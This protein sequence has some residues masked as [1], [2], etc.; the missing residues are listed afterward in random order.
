MNSILFKKST[1]RKQ[2][3]AEA[4]DEYYC[5]TTGNSSSSSSSSRTTGKKNLKDNNTTT[6]TTTAKVKKKK[7]KP[8]HGH[9]HYYYNYNY[10]YN[11]GDEV[12][13]EPGPAATTEE[14][15]QK[16]TTL[17]MMMMQRQQTSTSLSLHYNTILPIPEH[18]IR[19]LQGMP[20]SV[21]LSPMCHETPDSQ[22]EIRGWV[23]D[24]PVTAPA[25][26]LPMPYNLFHGISMALCEAEEADILALM[27][28]ADDTRARLAQAVNSLM[29]KT[30]MMMTTTSTRDNKDDENNNNNHDEDADGNRRRSQRATWKRC[31]PLP[32][33]IAPSMHSAIRDRDGNVVFVPDAGMAQPIIDSAH[34]D[35]ELSPDGFVGFYFRWHEGLGQSRIQLYVVCQ[36]YLPKACL[37]FADMVHRAG[38]LCTADCVCLS[39]EAQWLRTA[40]SRNR[41]RIIA[42]VCARMGVKVPTVEDYCAHCPSKTPIALVTTETLHHD[43]VFFVQENDGHTHT[44][45]NSNNNLNRDGSSKEQQFVRTL[46]YCAHARSA[47]NGSLCVMAPWEGIWVFR[48]AAAGPNDSSGESANSAY[49]GL[50]HSKP[51]VVLPTATPRV[52]QKCKALTFTSAEPQQCKAF[53]LWGKHS[54]TVPVTML[55]YHS[56]AASS[57]QSGASYF[58]HA[59]SSSPAVAAIAGGG[60]TMAINKAVAAAAKDA[61]VDPDVLAAYTRALNKSACPTSFLVPNIPGALP[62]T[63]TKN[64]GSKAHSYYYLTFDEQV[65]SVMTSMGWSRAQGI[66][67]LIPMACALFESWKEENNNTNTN[68]NHDSEHWQPAKSGKRKTAHCNNSS[69]NNNMD[70]INSCASFPTSSSVAD[71]EEAPA[72]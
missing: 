17:M 72:P 8:Q 48:G 32:T 28:D 47:F 63:A 20:G 65:L 34:W 64:C 55:P 29:M 54:K 4:A 50:P 6:T 49:F 2:Q 26:C 18:V 62:P 14:D 36:S 60:G 35:P 51:H 40:C 68:T 42:E 22:R 21:R 1:S 7:E 33:G 15:E 52:R 30:M 11:G 27:R 16:M 61:A 5:S 71:D 19:T 23:L 43:L 46:N 10:N 53:Q 39:E 31:R 57:P 70:I 38:N 37:E 45:N 13:H 69:S 24:T 12:H 25:S 3:A 41:A 9:H 59:D 66:S 67:K 58:Y 56:A 44:H